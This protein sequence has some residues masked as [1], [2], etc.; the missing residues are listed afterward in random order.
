MNAHTD[1]AQKVVYWHRDLPPLRAEVV[2]EDTLEAVSD[3]VQGRLSH[4]DE[5]WTACSQNLLAHA[6]ERIEQEVARRGCHYAHVH[7]ETIDTRHDEARGQAW[8]YGR[9]HYV[10]YRD[11]APRS[12][13]S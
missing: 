4:R 1:T 12:Q 5:H 2:G 10:L 3:R 6:R 9:F 13:G 7:D 11:P 8:L